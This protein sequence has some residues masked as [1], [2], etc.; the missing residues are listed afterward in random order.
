MFSFVERR[1]T[2]GIQIYWGCFVFDFQTF[3]GR[4]GMDVRVV[5]IFNRD[6]KIQEYHK[7]LSFNV[8]SI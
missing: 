5:E 2:C 1:W 6:V 3:P 4:V 7:R 8:R